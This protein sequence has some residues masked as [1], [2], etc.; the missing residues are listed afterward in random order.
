MPR[1]APGPLHGPS[2]QDPRDEARRLKAAQ[3][4]E[5]DSRVPSFGRDL[6][7]S[8]GLA[9]AAQ[10]FFGISILLVR[11]RLLRYDNM[12]V[13]EDAQAWAHT[14]VMVVALVWVFLQMKASRPDNGFRRSG[15]VPF[16]LLAVVLVTLVQLVTMLVWPVLI[17]PDLRPG[18]VLTEVWSDPR[19]LLIAAGLVLCLTAVF[20]ALVIPMITCGWKAALVCLLPY[21]GMILLGAYLANIVLEKAPTVEQAALWVGVGIGSLVLLT[22]SLLLVWWVRRRESPEAQGARG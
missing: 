6:L 4:A 5:E 21:L 18:T 15:L 20:T 17:G 22:A 19:A 13:V 9:V 11:W 2:A 10:I 8:V 16:M 1:S 7:R 12:K 3:R 14:V